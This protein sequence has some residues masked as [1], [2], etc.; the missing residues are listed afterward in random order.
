M[1]DFRDCGS[2]ITLTFPLLGF[3]T[4]LHHSYKW[5]FFVALACQRELDGSPEQLVLQE[6]VCVLMFAS[7]SVAACGRKAIWRR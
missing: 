1:A 5:V 2:G 7:T 4:C 6:L 3:D